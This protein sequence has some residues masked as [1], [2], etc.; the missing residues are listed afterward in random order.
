MK[1]SG[2]IVHT[3]LCCLRLP[4]QAVYKQHDT[5]ASGHL[6]SAEL[7]EA[8]RQVGYS[9]SN[10]TFSAVV[11]RYSDRDGVVKFQDFVEC[12]VKLSTMTGAPSIN[13]NKQIYNQSSTYKSTP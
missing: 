5:D 10:A 13:N 12:V 6:S 4:S 3:Q 1:N 8:L 11:R 7:R 9:I 2:V